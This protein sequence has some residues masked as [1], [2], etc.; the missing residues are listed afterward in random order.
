MGCVDMGH[1]SIEQRDLFCA[2][3]LARG[4]GA[5]PRRRC[6]KVCAGAHRRAA[7]EKLL[8]QLLLSI[9]LARSHL[10]LAASSARAADAATKAPRPAATAA[11]S[12][13]TTA[14]ATAETT[15]LSKPCPMCSAQTGACEAT[16]RLALGRWQRCALQLEPSCLRRPDRVSHVPRAVLRLR[17]QHTRR[18]AVK[19]PAEANGRE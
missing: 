10:V 4:I 1:R 12:A 14:T 7:L 5:A 13:T 16:S 18:V 19:A 9:S 6:D 2:K 17:Q 15:A 11:A 8:P 3:H